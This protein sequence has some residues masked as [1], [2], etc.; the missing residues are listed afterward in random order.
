MRSAECNENAGA[1]AARKVVAV[2]R[3]SQGRAAWPPPP[4]E[5]RSVVA[6]WPDPPGVR[7]PKD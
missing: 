7:P 5:R 3:T 4:D 6:P 2:P 1:F